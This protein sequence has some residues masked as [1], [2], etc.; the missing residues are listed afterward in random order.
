M[1]GFRNSFLVLFSW[2]CI[3]ASATFGTWPYCVF[4]FYKHSSVTHRWVFGN[5]EAFCSV[6]SDSDGKSWFTEMVRAAWVSLVW[7][8][9]Q[10]HGYGRERDR[11][12]AIV[13]LLV[14]CLGTWAICLPLGGLG[15]WGS[16]SC[17]KSCS[18]FNSDLV[19]RETVWC[20]ILID[21]LGPFILPWLFSVV[22]NWDCRLF[23]IHCLLAM[24]VI[25]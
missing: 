13:G 4:P 22:L 12:L 16:Q 20:S 6:S 24:S 14:S 2:I 15:K 18:M 9:S 10:H 25:W 8:C 5:M 7:S 21:V 23:F 19:V 17:E 11:H 1:A 3:S